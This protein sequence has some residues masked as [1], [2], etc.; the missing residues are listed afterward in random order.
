MSL[1]KGDKTAAFIG[2]IAGGIVL[3][4]IIYLTV[5]VTNQ[6]FAGHGT[7][8]PPAAAPEAPYAGA[9]GP[10]EAPTGIPAGAPTTVPDTILPQVAPGEPRPITAQPPDS[11][12]TTTPRPDTTRR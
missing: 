2:L 11:R 7:P 6:I 1:H 10:V 8:E 9:E 4:A 12:P 5:A 3:F